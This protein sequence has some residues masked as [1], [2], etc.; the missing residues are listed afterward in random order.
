MNKNAF[1]YTLTGLFLLIAAGIRRP[2]FAQPKPTLLF[3]H[4]HMEDGLS[5]PTVR[6]FH[7]DR[8]GFLWMG[9]ENGLTRF[10]GSQ[11]RV[12]KHNPNDSLSLP[13]DYIVHII[14]DRE[15]DLWVGT[16]RRLA[17]YRY[18]DDT[19]HSL[20]FPDLGDPDR[21]YYAFPFFIDYRG[22][23]WVHL[24]VN[25]YTFRPGNSALTF[26]S[27]YSK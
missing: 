25:I 22:H 6:M 21:N 10:D 19:F 17:K 9:T 12:Y 15:G 4:L 27:T 13:G 1:L 2:L 5:D 11:T 20:R 7:R 18:A 8:N 16:Q 3:K 14:E 24:A 23:V 26:I